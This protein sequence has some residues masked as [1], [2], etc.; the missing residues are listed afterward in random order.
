MYDY[1]RKV[2]MSEDT[3]MVIFVKL[4]RAWIYEV[5]LVISIVH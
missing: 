5:T 1:I 4:G 3:N 2:L